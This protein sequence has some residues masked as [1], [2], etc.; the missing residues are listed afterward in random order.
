MRPA[1]AEIESLL[2]ARKLDVTLTTGPARQPD[3]ADLAS[4]GVPTID[5]ALGGGFRRGHLS[6]LVG[7]RSAGRTS[8][9]CCALAA[10]A[11]RGEVVAL[12]DTCDRFDPVS[13]ADA[14]LDLSRLLWVRESGNASRAL[15]A[16]S[17]VLQAGSFGFVAFDLADVASPALRG[18]PFTTWMRL[19]RVLEGTQT[20]AVLVAAEHLARSPGGVTVAFEPHGTSGARWAGASDRAR[21]LH[22]IAMTPRV[23]GGR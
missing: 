7:P 17:L 2:R 18:F 1:R 11:A 23:I 9:M 8:L 20:V 13:A 4:T 15:R 6:E 22:G 14:G 16:M 10:A 5:A 21:L 12:I 19:A 3:A